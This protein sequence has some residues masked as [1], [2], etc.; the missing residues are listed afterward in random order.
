MQIFHNLTIKFPCFNKLSQKQRKTLFCIVFWLKSAKIILSISIVFSKTDMAY[1]PKYLIQFYQF[2]H[3][4][5]IFRSNHCMVKWDNSLAINMSPA[6]KEQGNRILFFSLSEENGFWKHYVFSWADKSS[7]ASLVTKVS[8]DISA[9]GMYFVN[10]RSWEGILDSLWTIL[11]K[12][13]QNNLKDVTT[14]WKFTSNLFVLDQELLFHWFSVSNL[15]A[16]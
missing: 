14:S 7:S 13:T 2:W 10:E 5:G 15:L 11:L 12:V 1:K 8:Q 6:V 16:A 3:I 4:C 9:T